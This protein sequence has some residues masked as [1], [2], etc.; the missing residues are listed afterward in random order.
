MK[1][2]R[3]LLVLAGMT[4]LLTPVLHA[5]DSDAPTD[6]TPGLNASLLSSLNLRGIGPAFM[7]GRIGD[8]AVDP[9]DRNTWYVA[10]ASGGVWKTDEL[11]HD[12]DTD[13]RPLRIVLDRLRGGGP[14]QSAYRVGGNGR[15]QQSA[16]RGI[17]R[18]RVQVA[19]RW[20]EFCAG[21]A[22]E[23]GTCWQDLDRPARLQGG[24]RGGS[25]SVVGAGRRPWSCIRPPMAERP[26]RWC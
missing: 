4:A 8:I 24:V 18:R 2:L 11:R 13:L 23:L 6:K 16:E 26:G 25:R 21:W 9:V 20:P 5:Q 19:R 10:A 22:G 17:R 14:A 7:S 15:E 1:S 3:K 12:L